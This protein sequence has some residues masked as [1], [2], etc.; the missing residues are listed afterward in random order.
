MTLVLL[1]RAAVAVDRQE[2]DVGDPDAFAGLGG[3]DHPA[4][5]DVHRDVADAAVVEDQIAGL[6][7]MVVTKQPHMFRSDQR[8]LTAQIEHVTVSPAAN[9]KPIP[10][11]ALLEFP[12]EGWEI[13]TL[14]KI[15]ENAD[16]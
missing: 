13:Q 7:D 16:E 15:G 1:S 3:V 5:T 6:I 8:W 4:A 11:T 2:V 10:D 9:A 12:P 14:G